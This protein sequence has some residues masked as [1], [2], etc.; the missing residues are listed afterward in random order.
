MLPY[1]LFSGIN[2][3]FDG[4]AGGGDGIDAFSIAAA[5]T[6]RGTWDNGFL[7]NCWRRDEVLNCGG[8]AVR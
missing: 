2:N 8:I 7:Y 4:T 3:I 1:A 5:P 6:A